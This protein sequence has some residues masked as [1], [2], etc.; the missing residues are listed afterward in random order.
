VNMTPFDM[1]I[2][3]LNSISFLVRWNVDSKFFGT[4]GNFMREKAVVVRM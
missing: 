4:D 1:A 2:I 3:F